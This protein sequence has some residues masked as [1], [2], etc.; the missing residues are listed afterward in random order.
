M[1]NIEN[2]LEEA[3]KWYRKSAEHGD[4]IAQQ[5]LGECYYNGKGVAQDFEEAFKWYKK[6]ADQSC[7]TAPTIVAGLYKFG[8]GVEQNEEEAI[9]WYRK[10]NDADINFEHFDP[11]DVGFIEWYHKAAE[12]GN[13][14]AQLKL[15]YYYLYGLV[16]GDGRVEKNIDEAI[17]WYGKAADQGST[18]AHFKLGEIHLGHTPGIEEDKE[19]ALGWFIKAAERGDVY[20]NEYAM[21]LAERMNANNNKPDNPSSLIALLHSIIFRIQCEKHE[22]KWPPANVF[23]LIEADDNPVEDFTVMIPTQIVNDIFLSLRQMTKKGNLILTYN[24]YEDNSGIVYISPP[25]GLTDYRA[26][27]AEY[28]GLLEYRPNLFAGNSNYDL[29]IDNDIRLFYSQFL[30]ESGRFTP[31]CHEEC[32]FIL[33]NRPIW[34]ERVSNKGLGIPETPIKV[35]KYNWSVGI[36]LADTIAGM[37]C[38]THK[39]IT[40]EDIRE[41]WE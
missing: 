40:K 5:R 32:V 9:K 21:G 28:F 13:V 4:K 11:P 38:R 31:D 6:A 35:G 34:I 7:G 23:E 39:I 29:R 12:Q 19:A 37:F 26:C 1:E 30:D 2:N 3:F 36:D 10:H 8:I 20:A 16:C 17:K 33:A 22:R 25:V 18:E 27:T 41:L 15:G 24:I 14:P